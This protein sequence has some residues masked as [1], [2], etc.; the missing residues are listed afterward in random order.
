MTGPYDDIIH[1]PHP[2]SKKHPRMPAMDRAAQFSSF[3]ALTGYKAAIQEA[4]RLTCAPMELTEEKKAEIG[5]KL[6]L[7]L[8][9]QADN[10]KVTITYF[11]PD[12]KKKGGTYITIHGS[13]KK[14][15]LYKQIITLTDGTM[16]EIP[17]IAEIE[18]EWFQSMGMSD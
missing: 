3:Q 1:L 9:H 12:I 10:P 14:I 2:V 17:H 4:A 6:S 15:N 7:I 13:L 8:K 18:S 5:Q 16:V 11:Q